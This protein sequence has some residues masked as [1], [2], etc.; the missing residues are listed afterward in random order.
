MVMCLKKETRF[1][2]CEKYLK[3]RKTSNNILY[4]KLKQNY[5]HNAIITR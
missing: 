2:M 4:K 5:L 3:T 1:K